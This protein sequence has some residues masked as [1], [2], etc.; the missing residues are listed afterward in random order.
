VPRTKELFDRQEML[1]LF[2][3][4]YTQALHG[5]DWKKVPPGLNEQ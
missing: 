1:A 3:L 4:G 2:N 5:Y